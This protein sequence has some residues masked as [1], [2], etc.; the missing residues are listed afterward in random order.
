MRIT[1]IFNELFISDKTYTD[2][3]YR[4]GSQ[5]VPKEY[6]LSRTFIND[7]AYCIYNRLEDPKN[8]SGTCISKIPEYKNVSLEDAIQ[9]SQNQLKQLIGD[10]TPYL[11]LS[12]GIDSTLVF[13]ALL[14]MDIPFTVASDSNA[15]MEYPYLFEK[16]LKNEFNQVTL[17]RLKE[18]SFKYLA[19]NKKILFVTGEI[20]DQ[21]MGSM[22][23]L[24]FP[25]EERQMLLSE[26][27]NINL[28]DKISIIKYPGNISE[29]AV[30]YFHC[31]LEWLNKTKDT[32]TVSEFLWALNFIY[33]YTF[34]IYRLYAFNMI[35]YG[36]DKNAYHF[37]DTEK[38]QQ[39]AMSHYKVNCNFKRQREY[40]Q[41]FKNWIYSQNNDEQYRTHKVKV[42]SLQV[43]I[44]WRNK[45]A[46]TIGKE[47]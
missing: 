1:D 37:F 40:K 41:E 21:I 30:E 28:F 32:C 19:N 3:N 42:P 23:T 25:Y 45:V 38:F 26:A 35:Q 16:I 10:K 2:L 43:S 46:E 6:I 4:L 11:M 44:H 20:G 13:Y 36:E 7:G 34:V 8:L 27:I 29:D 31:A 47:V 33:K 14:Q 15:F 12:G 9:D 18:N 22:V 17:C 24:K 5:N 39:Y